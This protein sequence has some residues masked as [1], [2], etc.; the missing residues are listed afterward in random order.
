MLIVTMIDAVVA[1]QCF[2]F[3]NRF[4]PGEKVAAWNDQRLTSATYE[5]TQHIVGDLTSHMTEV[6]LTTAQK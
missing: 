4:S 2:K 1:R 5:T 6:L 3:Q